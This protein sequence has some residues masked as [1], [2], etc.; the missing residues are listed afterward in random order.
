MTDGATEKVTPIQRPDATVVS[1]ATL[2]VLVWDTAVSLDAVAIAPSEDHFPVQ[3]T[4]EL[5]PAATPIERKIS[6]HS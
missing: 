5:A 3:I 6:Q 1:T 2:A 4:F